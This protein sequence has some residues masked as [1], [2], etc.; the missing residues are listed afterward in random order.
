VK[1]FFAALRGD[2]RWGRKNVGGNSKVRKKGVGRK[3]KL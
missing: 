2:E 1:V 3:G